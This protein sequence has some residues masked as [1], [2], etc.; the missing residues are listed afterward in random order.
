V[1]I[2]QWPVYHDREFVL[3]SSR[4]EPIGEGEGLMITK[5]RSMNT[6]LVVACISVVALVSASLFDGPGSM[7]RT[8]KGG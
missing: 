8:S 3:C 6:A 1:T 2:A 5:G 7:C 4:A